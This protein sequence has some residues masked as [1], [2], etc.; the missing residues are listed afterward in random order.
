LFAQGIVVIEGLTD[1]NTWED[2]V[3]V[4]GV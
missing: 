2:F 4:V 3:R 1:K